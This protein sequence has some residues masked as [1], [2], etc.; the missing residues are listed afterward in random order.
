MAGWFPNYQR[1]RKYQLE[2]AVSI[3]SGM[4]LEDWSRFSSVPLLGQLAGIYVWKCCA[5][6][7]KLSGVASKVR[8]RS[9]LKDL[10]QKLLL[11]VSCC[12][13]SIGTSLNRFSFFFFFFLWCWNLKLADQSSEWIWNESDS[14]RNWVEWLW[15]FALKTLTDCS[16]IALK[17]EGK[18][19]GLH[20]NE[21]WILIHARTK[22]RFISVTVCWR[23]CGAD[24]KRIQSGKMISVQWGLR[25][26]ITS[27]HH[28]PIKSFR[29]RPPPLNH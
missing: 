28:G 24:H 23:L 10:I 11:V 17:L 15:K 12:L 20:W 7:L 16:R 27:F 13:K 5:T 19:P 14:V 26:P 25:D 6:T 29:V 21:L 9:W 18:C 2:A 8:I 1:H 22:L 3:R 4:S